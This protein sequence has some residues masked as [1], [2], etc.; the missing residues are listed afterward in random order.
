VVDAADDPDDVLA[1]RDFGRRDFGRNGS[2]LVLR[3][4]QQDVGAFWRFMDDA[5]RRPDG[6]PDE[7]ARTALAA[8]MVGRWPS[9]APVTMA[10]ESD[11]PDLAGANDFAYH[12][13][14]A[15]GLGCPVGAHVRRANPRDSLPPK[16]GEAGSVAVNKRHRLLRRGR[17]YGSAHSGNTGLHFVAL[18]ADL[19]R[20]FEFVTHTWVLNPH[21]DGL[22]DDA[23]PVLGGHRDAGDPVE[24]ASFTRQARPV[25]RR[26]HDVPVFVTVRGGAYFFLPG[27]RAL[28]FLAS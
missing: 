26:V 5:T 3:T 15:G 20:Q 2:Y 12:A 17:P 11:A 24:G 8:H 6:T 16:P 23:D 1:G 10:P 7:A 13:T 14:D 21:F 4:L 22:Y 28:R 25:R 27:R 18:C 19:A 9:G